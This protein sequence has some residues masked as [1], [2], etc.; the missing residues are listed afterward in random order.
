MVTLREFFLRSGV[1]LLRRSASFFFAFI[2]VVPSFPQQAP[3][4]PKAMQM[5]VVSRVT[6]PDVRGKRRRKQNLYLRAWA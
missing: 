4:Q 6:V 3:R 5:M 2:L 1:P